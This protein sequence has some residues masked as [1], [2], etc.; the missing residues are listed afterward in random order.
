MKIQSTYKE[1]L[2]IDQ[3]IIQQM[4]ISPAFALFNRN[5]IK[6]FKQ[7]NAVRLKILADTI[8]E[9]MESHVN[10]DPK[11]VFKQLVMPQGQPNRWDFKSIEN[12]AVFRKD[13]DSFLSK[14]ISI[15]I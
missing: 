6:R 4:D 9:L 15:S 10:K 5:K 12:A 3:D 14:E 1:L 7:D 13:L 11:G 8:N 2:K